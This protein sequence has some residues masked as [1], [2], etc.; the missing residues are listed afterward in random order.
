MTNNKLHIIITGETGK[1]H[2][3]SMR[4]N[5]PRNILITLAILTVVLGYGTTLR[6]SR[7]LKHNKQL[8]AKTAQLTA[9]LQTK[10]AQ[11]TAELQA[12]KET[13]TSELQSTREQ[14]NLELDEAKSKL[15]HVIR[16]KNEVTRSYQQQ[17]AELKQDRE[18]LLEGS[19]SRLDERAKVIETVIDKLGVKVMM[20]DDPGHSGGPYIALDETY[21]N[22]LISDTDR[23]LTALQKMP[24][25]RPINT[26]ISSRYGRRTDPL[27]NKKAF[28]AGIDFKG[29]TGDKVRSTG[30]ALVRESAYNKGGLGYYIVLS[31]GNGYDTMYAH[32]SKRLVRPGA[33]V[34]RG[35]VIGLV[36]NTGRSTGP[37]LHYEVR[38]YGKA[39][40]P[41]KYMQIADMTVISSK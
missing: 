10:T 37:H 32:L 6:G 2:C 39:V 1:N 34:K 38:R 35:Q 14:L 27:N 23:Y 9:E 18:T 31:H 7:Y 24:L 33:R 26:K 22:K 16:E 40:N 36:G 3:L 21:Y 12:S 29:D 5:T 25:G 20:E 30:D 11:L 19:I 4:K 13:L 17:L 28:H 8:Q 15:A 41:M